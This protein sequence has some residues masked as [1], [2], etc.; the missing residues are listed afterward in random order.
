MRRPPRATRCRR[1]C[2]AAELVREVRL[3][4]GRVGFPPRGR[5]FRDLLE[6]LDL[7]LA[8]GE[9]PGGDGAALDE[10]EGTEDAVVR[11]KAPVLADHVV[12]GGPAEQERVEGAEEARLR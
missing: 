5:F 12:A 11:H 6:V 3:D 4:R 9:A 1:N 8:L 10:G 2:R 7:D